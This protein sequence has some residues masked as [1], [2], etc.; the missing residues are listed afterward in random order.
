MRSVAGTTPVCSHT[1]ELLTRHTHTHTS[2]RSRPSSEA[3][4]LSRGNSAQ[5]STELQA[6]ARTH[7]AAKSASHKT[8]RCL[9]WSR[10]QESSGWLASW[11]TESGRKEAPRKLPLHRQPPPTSR[12]RPLE[13]VQQN[14]IRRYREAPGCRT[15]IWK[16]WAESNFWLSPFFHNVTA[17]KYGRKARER[18]GSWKSRTVPCFGHEMLRPVFNRCDTWFISKFS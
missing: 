13:P 18:E 11:H 3:P 12:V 1:L 10:W 17:L 5:S 6:T 8:I 16:H 2:T 4:E 15:Q 7:P 14:P 9:R